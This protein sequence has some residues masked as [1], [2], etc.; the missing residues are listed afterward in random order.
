MWAPAREPQHLV[1]CML[2]WL[3]D[4]WLSAQTHQGFPGDSVVENP[5]TNAGDE[6]S[7]AGSGRSPEGGNSTLLQFSCLEN[8]T[9]RGAWRATVHRVA[10]VGHK[11]ATK[12]QQQT[13]IN[14][15]L[16]QIIL[17]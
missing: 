17:K 3:L 7:I 2:S 12:Q 1:A 15:C 14:N 9:N 11:L 10:R 6:G 13:F 8:A 4:E 16:Y 5:P